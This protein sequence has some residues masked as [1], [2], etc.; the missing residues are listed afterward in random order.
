MTLS[1]AFSPCPNDTFIFDALVNNKINTYGLQFEPL[2]A[3]VE[4]LNQNAIAGLPVISKISYGVLPLVAKQYV[5][6]DAGSAL[7]S[8]VGP[9][10]IHRHEKP[11]NGLSSAPEIPSETVAI[12]GKYTTAHLLFTLAYP[13]W[14]EKI[15]LPYDQIEDY[16]SSGKGP[17]VIIHENRFTYEEKGLKLW[18]DLGKFWELKTNGPIPLGGIV[19][20][21]DMDY[22]LQKKVEL[23]IRESIDYAYTQYP[24]LNDY[25][26]F[27][28]REMDE[29]VM[30]K[31]IELYVNAYSMS[32]G[33]L[34]RSAVLELMKQ[35]STVHHTE[36]INGSVFLS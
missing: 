8:G 18:Q 4:T 14:K 25:I 11:V 22:Q 15:F 36:P 12:P 19:I 26:R 13:E 1:L 33:E 9:L 24:V 2:L 16:V 34:G 6:L 3:D 31:H 32:L 5:L 28:A 10:L 20:R 17:G 35:F 21:R 27:H 30:R 29:T 7:G 23:L